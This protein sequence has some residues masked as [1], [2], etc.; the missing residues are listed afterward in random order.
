MKVFFSQLQTYFE[1]GV[2][3][4]IIDYV[5]TTV[6]IFSLFHSFSSP[7]SWCSAKIQ[8]GPGDKRGTKLDWHPIDPIDVKV[9][10]LTL[11]TLEHWSVLSRHWSSDS[12]AWCQHYG[13]RFFFPSWE[14]WWMWWS[15]PWWQ[16]ARLAP[17]PRLPI[18]AQTIL[19]SS[20]SRTTTREPQQPWSHLSNQLLIV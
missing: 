10:A 6:N 12:R 9:V 14:T 13:I 20:A 19:G 1:L 7:S 8:R 5:L 4:E 17:S 18:S 2:I 11:P 15:V 16:S 3:N